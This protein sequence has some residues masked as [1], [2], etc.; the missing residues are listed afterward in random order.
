LF[1]L[2]HPGF[3]CLGCEKILSVGKLMLAKIVVSSR[4][5]K[6]VLYEIGQAVLKV[7]NS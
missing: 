2:Q 6:I 5:A 3:P 4:N 1:E 7:K